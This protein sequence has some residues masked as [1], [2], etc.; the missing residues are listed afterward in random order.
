MPIIAL[1]IVVLMLSGCVETVSTGV[2]SMGVS[3]AK[4]KTIGESIDDTAISAKIK[5]EFV[6]KGF[7]NLYAKINVEV[8]QSRVLYTGAVDSEE[9]I[10]TAIDIAWNQKG[11]KEVINEL[12]ISE[13]SRNFHPSQY[14]KDSWVTTQ[15]KSKLFLNRDIKF[16]NYTVVTTS[17]I[18]Y[19]FGIARSEE[20]LEKVANIAASIGGVEKVVSHVT[21]RSAQ[22]VI[23][24]DIEPE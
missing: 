22:N 17:N 19:L 13:D 20:E 6:S 23:H 5:K 15:I 4:D 8:V 16:V 1:F 18:V 24:Q 12:S 7:K 21:V 3:A 14:A 9:D 11:V 2:I 10:I